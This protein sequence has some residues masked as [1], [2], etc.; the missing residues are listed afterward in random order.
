MEENVIWKGDLSDT[1]QLALLSF[2]YYQKCYSG[3]EHSARPNICPDQS[4]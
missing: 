2:N 3:H 4:A 1:E